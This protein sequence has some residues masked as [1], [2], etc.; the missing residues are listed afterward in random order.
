MDFPQDPIAA[1]THPNPYPYYALLAHYWP[2]YRDEALGLWVASGSAAVAAVLREPRCRVRPAEEPVPRA[3]AGSPAGE[4]FGRLVR[5]NDGDR[6]GPLKRAVTA[7][8]STVTPGQAVAEGRR[9]AQA[10]ARR[11]DLP[12]RP[13]AL[14]EFSFA[15][16]V[17]VLGALLGFAPDRLPALAEWVGD[18]VRCL[19]PATP[20]R[21]MEQGQHAAR[22]LL[23]AMAALLDRPASGGLLVPIGALQNGDGADARAVVL[24]N[25]IGFLTQA[26][27]ATAGLLGNALL[28]LAAQ[29]ELERQA[30]GDPAVLAAM[31]REVARHDPP[32]QNTRR[33]V[34]E[35]ARVGGAELR[36]GDTVLV[37]LAAANR[38]SAANPDPH[39]F[40]PFRPRRVSFTFGVGPHACPGEDL[41]CAIAA[42]GVAEVLDSRLDLAACAAGLRYRPS[43]NARIPLLGQ[44]AP[45]TSAGV[46]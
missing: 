19:A 29:P 30:R 34:A 26:Y 1:V 9:A 4:I 36:A 27:E 33:F 45:A 43:A 14:P 38:D 41:A 18:F 20:P 10:L 13:Q 8:L 16:P 3:L 23:D 25:G 42:A 2:L 31:V 7:A 11:L 22:A 46:A 28:A 40:D 6:H 39:Q 35:A 12:H 5:M 21:L 44:S 32:I 17:H 37:L 24:A 15:L